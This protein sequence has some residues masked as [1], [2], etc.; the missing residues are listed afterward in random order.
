[1]DEAEMFPTC[2]DCGHSMSMHIGPVDMGGGHVEP[3]GCTHSTGKPD[4]L[5]DCMNYDEDEEY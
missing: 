1:M 5:C 4:E 2:K 3:I